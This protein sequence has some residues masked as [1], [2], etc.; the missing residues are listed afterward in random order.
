MEKGKHLRGPGIVNRVLDLASVAILDHL[1][2]DKQQLQ[3]GNTNG[4]GYDAL[5]DAGLFRGIRH[6]FL[7]HHLHVVLQAVSS[8]LKS[9]EK[10]Q[11]VS[12]S[13]LFWMGNC[14]TFSVG[15]CSLSSHERHRPLQLALG[16]SA[17]WQVSKVVFDSSQSQLTIMINFPKGSRFLC[18]ACG[19]TDCTVY[20]NEQKAGGI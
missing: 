19:Q 1:G 18:P 3:P 14:L 8:R 5:H 2:G 13:S 16:L 10:G 20:D 15:C 17:P 12:G 9:I 7:C 4:V 6:A 11:R